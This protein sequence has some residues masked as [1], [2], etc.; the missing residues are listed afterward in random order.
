MILVPIRSHREDEV[1]ISSK[2]NSSLLQNTK[3]YFRIR[4]TNN[5]FNYCLC[6]SFFM[7]ATKKTAVLHFFSILLH[8]KTIISTNSGNETLPA[9]DQ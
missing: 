8:H 3:I 2:I 9:E 5:G 4:Q 1:E 7:E 6:Y